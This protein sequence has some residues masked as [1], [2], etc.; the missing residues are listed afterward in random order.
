MSLDLVIN[1]W[2]PLLLKIIKICFY[3]FG[4]ILFIYKA[5]K[6]ED[7]IKFEVLVSFFF[8]FMNIGSIIEVITQNF[9]PE[10]YNGTVYLFWPAL[11][12]E[13]LVYFSGFIAIGILTLGTELNAKIKTHG[14]LSIIPFLLSSIAK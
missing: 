13:A 10:F 1:Y 12:A 2:L 14:V 4:Q 3:G 7:S 11:S 9:Y 8:L 5:R 6:K